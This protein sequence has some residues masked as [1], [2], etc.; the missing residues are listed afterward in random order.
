[1]INTND[2]FSIIVLFTSLIVVLICWD[3]YKKTNITE[4]LIFAFFFLLAVFFSIS[5]SLHLILD[6]FI[7]ENN[8][9]IQPANRFSYNF[10]YFISSLIVPL[11]HAVLVEFWHRAIR[12][13]KSKIINW[14][15]RTVIFVTI[16]LYLPLVW[17]KLFYTE[18]NFEALKLIRA[19]IYFL[20]VFGMGLIYLELGVELKKSD[21]VTE[22]PKISK[23]YIYWKISILIVFIF[24]FVWMGKIIF[25]VIDYLNEEPIVATDEF[26][27]I[28]LIVAS[29]V[30]VIVGYIA[31]R[32]PEG[33]L[34]FEYQLVQAFK[35]YSLVKKPGIIHQSIRIERIIDY[36]KS[37]K[38]NVEDLNS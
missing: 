18:I 12:S 20:A 2:M 34:L 7:F 26:Y 17:E 8:I 32:H 23:F 14:F 21:F 9:N 29:F 19:F 4:F 28:A 15:T 11:N 36:L 5:V 16:L 25:H 6:G 27:S 24:V 3:Y 13:K 33:L 31:L 1:M 37:V 30:Y 22:N 10:I 38:I 35:M